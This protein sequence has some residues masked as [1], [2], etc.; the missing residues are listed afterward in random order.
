MRID[1]FQIGGLAVSP[2]WLIGIVSPLAG[3]GLA[4]VLIPAQ[5]VIQEQATDDVRGRVLT[6]QLTLANALSIPLLLAAGGLADLFGIPQIIIALGAILL[7]L[8]LLDYYY[9]RGFPDV[10]PVPFQRNRYPSPAKRPVCSK[11]GRIWNSAAI[12]QNPNRQNR[13]HSKKVKTLEIMPPGSRQRSYKTKKQV[14]SKQ[15]NKNQVP[16]PVSKFT[17][18][19]LPVVFSSFSPIPAEVTAPRRAPCA[20]LSI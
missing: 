11:D 19:W 1:P 7:P 9:V 13:L 18:P 12:A 6:V 4:L 17:T 15:K 10:P 3:I 16:A 14:K 2:M 8:A 20:T 5:T